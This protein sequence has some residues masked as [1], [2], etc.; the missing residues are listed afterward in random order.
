MLPARL[1]NKTATVKRFTPNGTDRL[2]HKKGTYT[3]AGT[4]AC[5]LQ[6]LSGR[7][8]YAISEATMGSTNETIVMVQ[9]RAFAN[10]G[11]NVTEADRLEID[12][13]TY[14]VVHVSDPTGHAHHL[15]IDLYHMKSSRV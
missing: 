15:E 13:E 1:L 12:G 2:N 4:F 7:E 9:H 5:S 14:H 11:A 10:P 8:T 6:T 3:D